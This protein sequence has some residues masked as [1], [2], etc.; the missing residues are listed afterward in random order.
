MIR[1]YHLDYPQSDQFSELV[2]RRML[3]DIKPIMPVH[4]TRG[5][6]ERSTRAER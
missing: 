6:L 1:Q 2:G 3:H 5:S 4:S